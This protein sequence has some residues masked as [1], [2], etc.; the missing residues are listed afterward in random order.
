M[1]IENKKSNNLE[2]YLDLDA[3]VYITR[4]YQ[5]F[6]KPKGF[7]TTN[8]KLKNV[9]VEYLTENFEPKDVD[10]DQVYAENEFYYLKDNNEDIE[11]QFNELKK[12]SGHSEIM[13]AVGNVRASCLM[14]QKFLKKLGG[15]HATAAANFEKKFE[16]VLKKE[17]STFIS[18][19]LEKMKNIEH[20]V[21]LEFAGS[22]LEMVQAN[23]ELMVNLLEDCEL[24]PEIQMPEEYERVHV[25]SDELIMFAQDDR[26][27]EDYGVSVLHFY[28]FGISEDKKTVNLTRLELEPKY[29]S[30]N[31]IYE[32]KYFPQANLLVL[33]MRPGVDENT[34]IQIYEVHVN[35]KKITM[36]PRHK[37]ETE[38][39]HVTFIRSGGVDYIVYTLDKYEKK[40]DYNLV[41][42]SLAETLENPKVKPVQSKIPMDILYYRPFK[43]N[44]NLLL[45]EG[46][47][48]ELAVFDIGHR[49]IL[50]YYK[51][52][53]KQDY[54]NYFQAAYSKSKNLLFLLHNNQS[55]AI[56]SSFRILP[57]SKSILHQ[58]DFNLFDTLK[59]EKLNPYINQYFTL[60]FNAKTCRLNVTDDDYQIL[61][62][63]RINQ[64]SKIEKAKEPV[65]LNKFEIRDSS[66]WGH[67][68]RVD[69]DSY[70]MHYF[71][72][73]S[74][75]RLYRLKDAE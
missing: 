72:Y 64:Q 39:E 18:N 49:E 48:D 37:I 75:M 23:D 66:C 20:S 53:K 36:E 50:G 68:L 28:N 46:D 65:K 59:T 35:E 44:N 74:V 45:I 4:N 15:A 47:R 63:L 33:L 12:Y 11:T 29:S 10:H 57:E 13:N 1:E 5:S 19:C 17:N 3:K 21:G 61:F 32:T 2:A 73:E 8:K 43:L 27:D 41:L 14:K 71:P 42:S 26:D 30:R 25:L 24:G 54:Y 56:I 38:A 70:F 60:Q 7:K 67:F 58:E 52:H 6:I 51:E 9:T 31:Y 69:G 16:N 55:G 40:S 22:L 34:I 62:T